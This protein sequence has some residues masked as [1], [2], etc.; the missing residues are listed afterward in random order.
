MNSI[1]MGLCKKQGVG[2]VLW[3]ASMCVTNQALK[4]AF[5][6]VGVAGSSIQQEINIPMDESYFLIFIQQRDQGHRLSSFVCEKALKSEVEKS[7]REEFGA[8]SKM[9]IAVDL[10]TK[11]GELVN[12]YDL[13]PNCPPSANEDPSMLGL[14]EIKMKR[15]KYKIK[16]VNTNPVAPGGNANQVQVLLRGIGAGYP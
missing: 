13:T 3:L 5:I 2:I 15:G 4:D 7:P 10:F 9:H 12:H 8:T 16:I 6:D 11:K 1:T 14:G